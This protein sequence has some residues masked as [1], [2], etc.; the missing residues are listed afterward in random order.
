VTLQE[1]TAAV[2]RA[3]GALADADGCGL[4]VV[5]PPELAVR[6]GLREYQHLLFEPDADP[7][8]A[9]ITEAVRVDYDSP[10]VEAFGALLDP[11]ARLALVDVPFPPPK[12]I[13]P[14]R[15]LERG[16]TVRNGV[17]RLRDYASVRTTY[18]CFVMEYEALADERRGSLMELWINPDARSLADWPAS[19]LEAAEPRDAT[20][21]GDQGPRL[22]AA[23]TL[24]GRVA[25]VMARHD[26]EDFLESLQRR[27]AG[28]LRRLREYFDGIYEAIRRKAQR[29]TKPETRASE[30]RRLDATRDAYLAR[31]A[32]VVERYRVQ[33]RVW[34]LVVV[35]C[36]VPAYQL[37]VQ[38][39]RRS[40]KSEIALSWNALN[41]AIEPRCCD[42]CARPIRVA[43]L[44][45]DQ[46][47]WLC[48]ACLAPCP[49]CDR[50]YCRA[51]HTRCPRTHQ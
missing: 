31:V 49:T 21:G 43:D 27:R 33:A 35:A 39:L 47:H 6:V 18:F 13:D 14:L 4:H 38:I 45:D 9:E 44:C 8:T 23:A 51:C 17:V 3:R 1:F 20:L 25:G 40:V 29:A 15:E 48:P 2:L 34:P 22:Q 10:L 36:S 30:V 11:A 26:L 7:T 5:A 24:A 41:R 50:P 12:P 16:V 28:D 37:R 19:L 46:A 42:G 32:D